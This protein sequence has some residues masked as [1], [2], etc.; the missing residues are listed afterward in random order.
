[1]TSSFAAVI[2]T[3]TTR[4]RQLARHLNTL[5]LSAYTVV[6][7]MWMALPDLGILVS[8]SAGEPF[9]GVVLSNSTVSL[10]L[11]SLTFHLIASVRIQVETIL[12]ILTH[13]PYAALIQWTS[14]SV[15][16]RGIVSLSLSSAAGGFW[17]S[18]NKEKS[19]HH[20]S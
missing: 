7:Q 18:D 17:L 10:S 6:S 11:A 4:C 15:W 16:G 12:S 2:T 3:T 20:Y 5:P 13:A 19:L 9:V 1:M 8:T 14:A